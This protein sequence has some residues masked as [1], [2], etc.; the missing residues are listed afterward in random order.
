MS[1]TIE[2]SVQATRDIEE[3]F[4]YI[5]DDNLDVAIKFLVNVEDSLDMLTAHPFIGSNR[6]FQAT[7]LNHLR[8]WRV[9]GFESYLIIYAVEDERIKLMRVINAKRDFNLIFDLD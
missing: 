7:K 6:H 2:K 8:I 9:K 5:A 3:A 1:Y 4:V